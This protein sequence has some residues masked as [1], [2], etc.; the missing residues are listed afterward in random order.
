MTE[1]GVLLWIHGG[2]W[3]ARYHEDGAA[4]AP[5][6]L[7][8]VA[9]TYRF[10][11]EAHWPAQL[12]DVRAAARAA[13]AA[14]DGLPLLVGGDSA[15]GTL[16]LHLALRGVDRPGDVT[17]GLAYWAPVD[18]LDPQWRRLRRHDDPWADLLGHPPAAGDPATVDATVASHLGSG[19]PVLLVQGREDASVPA[20]QSVALT[21]QLLAAG[22]PVHTWVT[23]GGHALDLA[24][25]D[26]HAVT[27]AFL[28]TVLPPARPD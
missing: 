19:V 17:A 20:A 18:P 8:V 28:D 15:G 25:P 23:H 16:A 5:L 27:A 2:G 3:R 24:R 13:R 14:A 22:H 1:R 9:A 4:L 7:R 26:I 21:G 6:G 10:V 12:D 11:S